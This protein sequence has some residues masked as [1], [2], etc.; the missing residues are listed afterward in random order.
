LGESCDKIESISIELGYVEIALAYL[1]ALHRLQAEEMCRDRRPHADPC[2]MIERI[3]FK[4]V[5][6]GATNERSPL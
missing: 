6:L 4:K 1:A 3:F 2:C 5:W